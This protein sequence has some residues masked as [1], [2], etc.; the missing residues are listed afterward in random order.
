MTQVVGGGVVEGMIDQV[1][2]HRRPEW[3]VAQVM[4]E[5]LQDQ[6]A[7]RVDIVG[8][9]RREGHAP[10]L[11]DLHELIV[12]VLIIV[13]LG[14]CPQFPR[15]VLTRHEFRKSLVEPHVGPILCGHVVAKPLMREL[16]RNQNP[17][18]PGAVL[19]IARAR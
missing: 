18:I 14:T 13:L 3:L 17:R 8:T 9:E 5:H 7:L 4:L 11:V 16:V 12:L 6:G 10:L 19:V 15:P 2:V 1:A